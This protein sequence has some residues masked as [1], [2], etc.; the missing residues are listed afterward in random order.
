VEFNLKPFVSA[1]SVRQRTYG[2]TGAWQLHPRL[3][4]GASVR[5]QRFLETAATLRYNDQFVLQQSLVQATAQT[6]NG[7][8]EVG[9]ESDTTF[10][11]G[12]KWSPSDK[13][14]VG[15]V[16][17]LGAEFDAPLFYA[18]ANTNHEFIDAADT[19]FHMP[20][21]A[22]IGVSIRP[23]PVLTI[24][25]DAVSVKYSN[26]VD[27]FVSATADVEGLEDPFTAEDVV[28]L[29]VGA[30]YLFSTKIPF[31]LRAGYWRD[32]AHSVVW[33]GPVNHPNFI[34]ESIL[35]PEGEDQ[36]HLSIGGG[37]AWQR[38]QIDL[39]YDTS[40]H[41]KVGSISMVTRF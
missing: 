24:N 29:R 6:S 10:S 30:E 2:L 28:E 3:S 9:E 39:A 16:Y 21:I 7:N 32:P 26:L 36:D 27:D 1:L 41:Y 38:F 19:R 5:H 37:L 22:G 25:I 14:S 34:A 18:D 33:N 8:V 35:F 17:K 12:F 13:I 31:A 4:V 15:G 20:D 11:A 23:I 40:K